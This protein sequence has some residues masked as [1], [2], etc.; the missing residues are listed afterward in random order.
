MHKQLNS[1]SFISANSGFSDLQSCSIIKAKSI[2]QHPELI[3]QLFE[4]EKL[5]KSKN[6]FQDPVNLKI[7]QHDPA[8]GPKYE[9]NKIVSRSIVG[10]PEIFRKKQP[11]QNIHSNQEFHMPT[12]QINM[13]ESISLAKKE[14]PLQRRLTQLKVVQSPV[15]ISKQ[16]KYEKVIT[17]S[18]LI[19]KI[20]HLEKRL[21][22]NKLD[23]QQQFDNMPFFQKQNLYRDQR[24]LEDFDKQEKI[25]SELLH[26]LSARISRNP[27]CSLMM[28]LYNF[29]RKQEYSNTNDK[30]RQLSENKNQEIIEIQE[31]N[32]IPFYIC[33]D[34]QQIIRKPHIFEKDATISNIL[35]HMNE[36]KTYQSFTTNKV[37]KEKELKYKLL[38]KDKININ[39]DELMIIGQSKYEQEISINLNH[40]YVIKDIEKYQGNEEEIL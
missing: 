39:I 40:K 18:E 31:Q 19:S 21:I 33:S 25:H 38:V 36:E 14:S 32:Q 29:R 3:S 2:D 15:K 30:M 6:I 1:I 5:Q 4:T 24:A 12:Q 17:G 26:S 11:T 22:Q 16:T 20:A 10:K 27:S 13:Q 9:K 28:D 34:R 23:E 7:L 37:L 8:I 35:K